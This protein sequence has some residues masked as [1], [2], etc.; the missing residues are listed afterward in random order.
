MFET[1]V[2]EKLGT[3]ILCSRTLFLKLCFFFY[4]LLLC[5]KIL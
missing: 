5:G 3:H 1:R 2:V 4:L